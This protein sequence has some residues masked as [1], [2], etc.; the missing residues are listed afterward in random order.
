LLASL[1]PHSELLV[2]DDWSTDGS[3]ARLPKHKSVRL[4]RPPRHLGTVRARNYGA[5][6]ARG[7]ILVFSDAH[8]LVPK[9]WF[10]PLLAPLARPGV[11]ATGPVISMMGHPDAKG[12]GLRFS[13]AAL[14]CEWCALQGPNPY[15]V[16][17][18]GAGFF[19]MRRDVFF[20]IGGFDGGMICYSMEDPDLDIRLWTFGYECVLVPSVDVVHLFRNNHWFNDW[21]TFLHNLLRYA[22]VHLGEERRKRLIDCYSSDETFPEVLAK[23]RAS[24]AWRRRREIQQ[25]RLYDDE[26]YFKKFNMNY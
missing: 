7:Q 5:R 9:G 17:I 1:A 11:G 16:P 15:S 12:Y 21:A 20:A 22:T 19:A 14:N 8:V 18:L 3:A 4:L 10:G 2:V 25:L 24:D 13:D 23:V 6:H 26:W